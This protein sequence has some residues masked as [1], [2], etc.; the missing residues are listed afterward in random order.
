[1]TFEQHGGTHSR[2]LRTAGTQT[3]NLTNGGTATGDAGIEYNLN[4]V[5][6]RRTMSSP[7]R[8][9]TST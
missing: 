7:W 9:T 3:I 6:R 1:M 8:R 5:R 4:T 2:F